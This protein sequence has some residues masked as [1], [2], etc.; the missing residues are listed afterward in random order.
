MY[1]SR[2]REEAPR[3]RDVGVRRLR[4]GNH[5]PLSDGRFLSPVV[6]SAGFSVCALGALT[7]RWL[8]GRGRRMRGEGRGVRDF[9]S[10]AQA[11]V[12]A[13][14][15]SKLRFSLGSDFGGLDVPSRRS[16]AASL[17]ARVSHV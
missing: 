16:G 9:P 14:G 1:V 15:F 11:P 3:R 10:R 2:A 17:L 5:F 4:T 13:R 12:W 7:N 6:L 8:C